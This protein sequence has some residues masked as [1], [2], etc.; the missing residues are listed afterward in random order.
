[1]KI[2]RKGSLQIFF[3]DL[4]YIFP[5]FFEIDIQRARNFLRRHCC[6]SRDFPAIQREIANLL[7]DQIYPNRCDMA[8]CAN[9]SAFKSIS[10]RDRDNRGALMGE[11]AALWE[12]YSK[13]RVYF[14]K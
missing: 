6:F 8:G 10:I 12:W 13:H 9:R 5:K 4:T 11:I 2:C 14:V 3:Q 7:V 1:M